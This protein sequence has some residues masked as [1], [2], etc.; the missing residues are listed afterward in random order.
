MKSEEVKLTNKQQET[1]K[2]RLYEMMVE[3][4]NA[5]CAETPHITAS[6][7]LEKVAD[8]L[9]AAGFVFPPC[10]VGDTVYWITEDG[11]I[12]EDEIFE[13][14]KG[15]SITHGSEWLYLYRDVELGFFESEV[16]ERVFRNREEAEAALARKREEKV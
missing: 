12:A 10:Q 15:Y 13:M 9:L 6:E 14:G 11:E 1:E 16:G 5:I 7:R 4:E 3:A 8:V 2:Q